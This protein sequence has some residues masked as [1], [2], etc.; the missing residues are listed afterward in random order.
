MDNEM[1][2]LVKLFGKLDIN[3]ESSPADVNENIGIIQT[4]FQQMKISSN[5]NCNNNN[6][7]DINELID[8]IKTLHISKNKNT[9][10]NTITAK[11]INNATIYFKVY[12]C[13]F[14]DNLTQFIPHWGDAF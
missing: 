8:S 2:C 4:L 5:N 6:N 3:S 12:G 14:S 9:N 1:N 13:C 10:I 11:L 7:N